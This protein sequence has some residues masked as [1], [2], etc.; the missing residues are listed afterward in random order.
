MSP[1]LSYRGFYGTS[2]PE[3]HAKTEDRE[4]SG[5]LDSDNEDSSFRKNESVPL[6]CRFDVVLPTTATVG[7]PD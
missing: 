5:A 2:K 1:K 4:E 7:Q 3:L 6:D